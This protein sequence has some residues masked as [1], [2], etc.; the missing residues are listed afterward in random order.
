MRF[1]RSVVALA[2]AALLTTAAGVAATASTR[3]L[4]Q[5]AARTRVGAGWQSGAQPG[6]RQRVLTLL[7][8]DRVAV[9]ARPGMPEQVRFLPTAGSGS[10]GAT[11]SRANGHTFVVPFAARTPIASGRVDRQLFDITTLLAQLGDDQA[12]D[13]IPVIIEYDGPPREA[14]AKAQRALPGSADGTALTS[15]GAR[16]ESVRRTTANEF[17]QSLA[18]TGL[19]KRSAQAVRKVSLDR[20]VAPA[21]DRSVPQIGTPAAW[22]RGLTGKGIKVAVLDTGIDATHPDLKGRVQAAKDFSGSG[23]ILDHDG[24]GTHVAGTVGGSGAGSKGKHRGVAPEV[25]LLNGKVIDDDGMSSESKVIAGMEWAVAQGAKVV[26]LSL[27]ADGTDGTS[28]LARSLD[29]LSKKSGTLFVAAAG[30][31]CGGRGLIQAPGAAEQALTVANLERDGSLNESSCLGPNPDHTGKPDIAAP[32][33]DIVSALAAGSEGQPV[34]KYYTPMTGTSMATPHVV[35]AAALLAQQHRDWKG[36]RLK[37]R[38]I[39]TADPLGKQPLDDA[40]TGRVDADQATDNSITVDTAE[41]EMGTYLWPHRAP[42]PFS[43]VLTYQNTSTTAVT[44]NLTAP[45][46]PGATGAAPKLS[47]TKL[48]VPAK[49]KASVTVSA[50]PGRGKVGRHTGR[51]IATPAKGDPLFTSYGW[52]LE[53]EMYDVTVKGILGDGTPADSLLFVTR[54]DGGPVDTWEGN[55]GPDLINGVAKMR[56]APGVYSI[57]G[58]FLQPATA[59]TADRLVIAAQPEVRIRKTTTVT[60]DARKAVPVKVALAGKHQLVPAA[61]SMAYYRLNRFGKLSGFEEVEID[62][63]PIELRAVPTSGVT[64]GKMEFSAASRLET[65]AYRLKLGTKE[66]PVAELTDGPRFAGTKQLTAVNAGTGTAADLKRAV[67]KLAVVAMDGM[68]AQAEIAEAAQRAKVGGV[69]FYD[70]NISGFGVDSLF[71]GDRTLRIPVLQTSRE[72]AKT[73]PGKVVRIDGA[74]GSPEVFD[75]LKAWAGRVPARPVHQYWKP[76][77]ARIAESYAVH[78]T[79]TQ[80]WE[81]KVGYTPLGEAHGLSPLPLSIGPFRRIAYV[82]PGQWEQRVDIGSADT[83]SRGRSGAHRYRT[84]ERRTVNWRGPVATS[85]LP[86]K[87]TTWPS[88]IGVQRTGKNL[89]IGLAPFVTGATQYEEPDGLSDGTYALS[90]KRDGKVLVEADELSLNGPVPDAPGNYQ[91]A[92]DVQ[93]SQPWWKYSTQIRSTWDFRSRAG[94]AEAMPLILADV[95]FPQATS[96]NQ[97]RVGTATPLTL[98]LRHQTGAPTAPFTG[99]KLLMSYDGRTW[100]PVPLHKKTDSVYTASLNHPDAQAGSTVSLKLDITDAAGGRLQQD[101]TKAYGLTKWKG[102]T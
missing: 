56:I 10:A 50:D 39:S 42:K 80:L 66:L 85:G 51:I 34:D 35:G 25:T 31:G 16:A 55:G 64:V 98:S 49:G 78:S 71:L 73:L 6:D 20:K 19:Q 44:L 4:A 36:D 99:V 81:S 60:L 86:S 65:P 48:V 29:A 1:S 11:V 77:L 93:R 69:L 74:L 5:E 97:V 47:T 12:S 72:V 8:G 14:A 75:L 9:T 54:P 79:A 76:Q 92:L 91:L 63:A 53:P 32:G 82:R 41:L 100:T 17:W 101:I 37:A 26:N 84:G 23:N 70:P 59:T 43:Q 27:H 15:I 38:L 61:S 40:G 22:K 18:G 95:N 28:A 2:G 30:N 21:L 3:G 46:D 62:D 88:D 67:G 45:L 33:T 83:S 24:H 13:R 96:L 52:F 102:G 89:V 58:T 94:A 90:L 7:T 68:Q 87:T 57:A